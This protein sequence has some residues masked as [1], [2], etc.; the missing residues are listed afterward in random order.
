[1]QALG[2]ISKT[3]PSGAMPVVVHALVAAEL[4]QLE[5]AQELWQQAKT[6]STHFIAALIDSGAVTSHAL[7]Q[8]VSKAFATP[9]FDLD[10]LNRTALPHGLIDEKI[11]LDHHLVVLGSKN[12]RLKIAT[13]DPSNKEASEALKRLAPLEFE[14]VVVD[15]DR[16]RQ[17]LQITTPYENQPNAFD[18][19]AFNFE[20]LSGQDSAAQDAP[21]VRFL[22][23]LLAHA[24]E[25]GASDVH[26]E[27]YEKIYRVRF[28]VDGALREIAAPP[29]H[30]K[31]NLASRIKVLARIDIAEKRI[32][33]DGRMKLGFPNYGDIDFRVSSLPTLFG[34][35]IVI[36]ILD[37]SQARLG[38]DALGYE[39]DDKA[40]LLAAIRRPFGMILATGP[41]GSGK[42]VSLY[43]C[44]DLLN[45]PGVNII[46]A[47]DPSEIHFSGINQVNVNE[48][49]GL[50][51][52]TA[53]RSF[54]RQDPDIIMVGE[55]RDFET[56]D[57]AVKAAQTGHL[58]LSTLH[59]NDAPSTITR[60]RNM[61]VASFNIASSV[62]LITA[63]RLARRL[64]KHCKMPAT[65]SHQ[66]LLDAGFH[67]SDLDTSW[68]PYHAVGCS[69]CHKGYK[70]RVGIFQ[71]MPISDAIQE[72]I[73]RD[74]SAV[75]IASQAQLEGVRTLRQSGLI[76]VKQG[77]TS[78][79]EVLAVTNE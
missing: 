4:I 39:D 47:E 30:L 63:Q 3:H 16:L 57:I 51:F 29:L 48:K 36:R 22:E 68:Q 14:W 49:A 61:G 66:T 58:L 45:Q 75:E 27:P 37:S 1:M 55:M 78:I 9:F 60:L 2:S 56:A 7:A 53:L 23:K 41:T 79:E 6:N 12:N 32:P 21:V 65:S 28:R 69:H 17:W 38:M 25:L 31:E 10:T 19:D 35:K 72:I 50:T 64:C 24:V 5:K 13:A 33:Q 44:L 11:C 34:E 76:K 8:T 40:L 52:A 62:S 18:W 42:T 67:A 26:L 77:L 43:A 54:L 20:S 74:G 71:V 15:F 46:T 73:L 70:G 59:T